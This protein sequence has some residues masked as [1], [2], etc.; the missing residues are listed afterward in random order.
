[1]TK[2]R[3]FKQLVRARM[4]KTGERYSTARAHVLAAAVTGA[5]AAENGDPVHAHLYD[6][7]RLIGG[8]Q[9]DL[10]A[11]R[12]ICVNA[13]VNGP[14]GQPLSEAMAFGLAGGVGFLYGV[15]EYGDTPTLAIVNRNKSMPDEFC[16]PLFDRLGLDVA[17]NETGG[18][19]TAANHLDAAIEAGTPA[20]CTTASGFLPYLGQ[21]CAEESAA[22]PH[23]IGVVGVN[24]HGDL[25]VDDRSPVPL[26]VPRKDI[27]DARAANR[28]A[29]HR[30]VTVGRPDNHELD[31]P[32]VLAEAVAYA[33]EGFNTPPVPQFASN[34]GLAG[35][36]KWQ[37]LLT[38]GTKKGWGTIFGEGRRA[39]IGLTRLYDCIHHSYTAPAAGRSLHADFLDEAA[40]TV[41]ATATRSEFAGQAERWRASAEKWRLSGER[42][43]EVA[44]RA[45]EAHPDVARSCELSDQRAAELDTGAPNPDTMGEAADESRKLVAD[46]AISAAQAAEAHADIAIMVADIV[47]AETE[48]L[49][50]LS[51]EA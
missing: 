2:N 25:L 4:A 46:C 50:L 13:G 22:A 6:S 42:W 37:D 12:N 19:K 44:A 34:I 48:A 15:F 7:I 41:A 8:Q 24:D 5:T 23:L 30:M 18:A 27:D 32:L 35:L 3:D 51:A 10:A 20:L 38:S 9:G 26:V 47:D 43:S 11:A 1:M 16:A 29:K 28:K 33:V 36:A 31:W 14:D 40:A 39:A 21:D 49:R 45:A 17:V